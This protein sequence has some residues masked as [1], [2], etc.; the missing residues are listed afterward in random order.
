MWLGVVAFCF[1]LAIALPYCAKTSLPSR[2][3]NSE[4]VKPAKPKPELFDLG[5]PNVTVTDSQGNVT[6]TEVV[7]PRGYDPILAVRVESDSSG[8]ADI[9]VSRNESQWFPDL[10]PRPATVVTVINAQ[11]D[12]IRVTPTAQ[13]PPVFDTMIDPTIG[14]GIGING[15]P[16]VSVGASL[17]RVGPV[18]LGLSLRNPVDQVDPTV[19][20][21][22]TVRIQDH[23]HL[24]ASLDNRKALSVDL[25][26]SF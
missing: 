6:R 23:L 21:G 10:N 9:V 7:V 20:G 4:Y 3:V 19:A 5:D 18:Y 2:S 16:N 13:T 1:I 8:S 26:Y 25:K 22:A 12:T 15:I 14:V 24:G 17:A 11:G